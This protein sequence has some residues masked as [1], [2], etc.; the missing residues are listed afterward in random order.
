MRRTFISLFFSAC[1]LGATLSAAAQE[2]RVHPPGV[3][4]NSQGVTTVFLTFGNLGNYRPVEA[5]WCGEL[6]PAAPALG[7]KCDPRTI[8]G[9]LPLRF[10]LSRQSGNQAFTDIMS[11]PAS[12]ARRA[13]QAAA[14]GADSRFF[15]V[16][17][18][19]H[20]A[21]AGPDQYV[22]VTCRL[23]GGGARV[24]FSLTDVKLAFEAEA[25]VLYVQPGETPPPLKA[26]LSYNGT[27]RL[28]GRWEVVLPGEELPEPRDLLTEASLPVEERGRQRRYTQVERFNVFLPPTGK[29]TLPGPEVARLPHTAEG[30]Y[31]V[32][33]RV[34]A[35]DDKEAD[36]DLAAAG[37]GAGIV[38][39]GAVAGFPLPVLRY[40]VGGRQRARGA[41]AAGP[42]LALL[43]P[44]D[45]A[46]LPPG[47]PL[48][49]S[50]AEAGPAAFYRLEV[51]DAQGQP[52]LAALLPSGV[53]AYRAPAWL[54]EKAGAGGL[55]WR[56][57]ALDRTGNQTSESGWRRLKPAAVK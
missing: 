54:W 19:V 7:N 22:A 4:V 42:R 28:K 14:D 12:V 52:L 56:V 37:A 20:Q 31:L 32:L 18:F 38:H 6:I 55:R 33:L 41:A 57:L 21:G 26:E 16:R 51:E 1:L 44:N 36:S 17:R 35:T 50:W 9:A 48:D 23:T 29:Y 2:I 13:F 15:Y 3:N 39:S 11:I 5:V 49:F 53:G 27:G 46:L 25:P 34:E 30:L 40:F 8:F 24:P 43:Q 47:R 10:D 45:E